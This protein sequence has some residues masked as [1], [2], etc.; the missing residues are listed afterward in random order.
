MRSQ[1][2]L[3]LV[4]LIPIIFILNPG[5]SW[6]QLSIH[7]ISRVGDKSTV[8]VKLAE[9]GFNS[10]IDYENF[11]YRQ[12]IISFL[13]ATSELF[14]LLFLEVPLVKIMLVILSSICGAI[15]VTE[16]KLDK[17]IRLHREHLESDF[18]AV[19]EMLTLSLSAGESPLMSMERISSTARGSLSR[20][21]AR[22]ISEVSEGAPFVEALDSMGRRVNSLLVRR[23]IDALVIAITRGAPVIDVL[24]SH[25]REA[26]DFQRNRILAAASKAEISMMIP[27]VFLIL[28]ISILF[29]LW[30]S[31]SNLNLFAQG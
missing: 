4:I 5:F 2:V 21:F 6:E 9:L 18:P 24:H 29:A 17:E 20:E 10:E 11:R 3:L 28:P 23:F 14:L 30:P 8:K 7:F 15:F 1:F 16:K 22:V 31:L 26:R 12:L 27:V 19:I 25:A 13:L